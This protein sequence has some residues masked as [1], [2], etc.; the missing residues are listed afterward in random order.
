MVRVQHVMSQGT[1]VADEVQPPSRLQ[2]E[3]G[4]SVTPFR[5]S[6]AISFLQTRPPARALPGQT[7][8]PREPATTKMTERHLPNA[9]RL[10]LCECELRYREVWP[11]RAKEPTGAPRGLDRRNG[12]TVR[13]AWLAG[14]GT[15]A[16]KWPSVDDEIAR[17]RG[18]WA[19][20][21]RDKSTP[22]SSRDPWGLGQKAQSPDHS[23]A[24]ASPDHLVV[25]ARSQSMGIVVRRM[26]RLEEWRWNGAGKS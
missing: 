11:I 23:P 10:Q 26:S 1:V 2:P 6:I 18:A 17:P 21:P 13:R 4:Q 7:I 25:G 24:S 20:G 9:R 22:A 3:L 15:L 16:P 12:E 14:V 19:G 8:F 5:P